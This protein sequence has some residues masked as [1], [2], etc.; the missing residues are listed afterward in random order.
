LDILKAVKLAYLMDPMMAGLLAA[1]KAD[2]LERSSAKR[3]AVGLVVSRDLKMAAE[4]VDELVDEKVAEMVA[5][6]VAEMVAE[7]VA[8]LAA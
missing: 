1:E 8:A 5:W 2:K 4:K 3:T 6:K 7:M